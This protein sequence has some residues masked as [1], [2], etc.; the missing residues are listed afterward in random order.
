MGLAIL[1]P[2][3]RYRD[4]QKFEEFEQV[5]FDIFCRHSLHGEQISTTYSVLLMLKGTSRRAN[6]GLGPEALSVILTTFIF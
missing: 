6:R 2:S 4:L 1:K 5:V 3:L